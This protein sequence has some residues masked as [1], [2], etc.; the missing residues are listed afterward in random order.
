MLYLFL[1]V[2]LLVGGLIGRDAFLKADPKMLA[3]HL[4][5]VGGY[6]AL[7]LAF[8]LLATGRIISAVPFAVIGYLLVGRLPFLSVDMSGGTNQSSERRRSNGRMTRE[9]AYE[10]LGLKPGAS[11][12]EILQAHRALMMKI[13]PDH[14]GSTYLATKLNEAKDVLL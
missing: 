14:G 5:P 7:M 13:H 2:I 11:R 3:K 4:R 1:G 6:T 8:V 10:V 9:E 12:S